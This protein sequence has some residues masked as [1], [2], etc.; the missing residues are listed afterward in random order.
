MYEPLDTKVVEQ[1]LD[2]MSFESTFHDP[3]ICGFVE[4]AYR[5]CV[6]LDFFIQPASSS[7]KYHPTNELGVGGLC[8]HTKATMIMAKT[9]FK[10]FCF[11]PEEE[12]LIMAALALHDIAKPSKLH[13]IEVK[14][15]LDPMMEDYYDLIEKVIPLIESHMG[16]WDQFGKL[17]Q[18][19]DDLQRF[20]HLCDYLASRRFISIDINFKEEDLL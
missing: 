3:Q 15:I 10:L 9:L 14:A 11:E 20:V 16:Q 6:P 13:P 2:L 1:T 4:K 17:P 5:T 7:G 12:D 8:R 19:K 18:P